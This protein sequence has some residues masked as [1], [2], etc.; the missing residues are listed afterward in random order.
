MIW[1]LLGIALF[2][3][4]ARF[5]LRGEDLSAYDVST[6]E[7][8]DLGDASAQARDE[9]DAMLVAG[10]PSMENH[11]RKKERLHLMRQY[12]DGLSDGQEINASITPVDAGGITAEWVFAPGADPARR[13]LYIH[14]GAFMM[15]SP[16]SHRNITSAFSRVANAAVLAIDYRLMPE[17][18]RLEGVDDCRQA[19]RWLLDNGPDGPGVAQR[20]FVGGDSAGGNLTLAL[21][22]WIRDEGLRQ[23]DAAVALSPVTDATFN[24]PSLK[25][26]L[27]TDTML[28][29]MF[30]GLLKV[31]NVLLL[32]A[33]WLQNR[34][35]PSNPVI[36]P[37]F[38]D[39]SNLPPILV[40]AS[41][42]EVLF[43]DGRRYVN[44]ALASGSPVELQS[45]NNMPHVWHMFYPAL[46]EA[47]DAWS[48]IEAFL[49]KAEH[50]SRGAV[51]A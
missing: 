8:F 19:Y 1:L 2:F 10:M 38:A 7:Y 16:K 46:P 27:A 42:T 45:W 25:A 37:V 34:I 4:I 26:N 44:K 9:V 5:Y 50:D 13:V 12:M 11:S 48:A 51:A 6:G 18:K 17:N 14:G 15:G 29:P 47:R 43:D 24:A 35:S 41:T 40:H 31:P 28:R 30:T 36:S 39:L 21:I 22:H 20:V 3:L 32:W 49:A 33:G 23:A